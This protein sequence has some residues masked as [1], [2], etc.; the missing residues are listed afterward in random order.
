MLTLS[1]L[2]V[3]L[4]TAVVAVIL[5]GV[6]TYAFVALES[7]PTADPQAGRTYEIHWKQ[8]GVEYLTED[9]GRVLDG[10]STILMVVIVTAVPA[11]FVI[12]GIQR[13]RER[14]AATATEAPK[15]HTDSAGRN[16]ARR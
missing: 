3:I 16:R 1:R 2:R 15:P 7:S 11:L 10:I 4:L 9:Q 14:R 6:A 5:V 12:G 13:V 8:Y